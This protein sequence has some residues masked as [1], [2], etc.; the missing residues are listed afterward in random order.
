MDNPVLRRGPD[1]R[2]PP[3]GGSERIR[4]GMLVVPAEMGWI[5][6]R[7]ATDLISR[8]LRKEIRRGMFIMP[9]PRGML[10]MPAEAYAAMKNGLKF[11]TVNRYPCPD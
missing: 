7:D 1:K 6:K 4:R 9:V 10:V 2:V 11:A 5:I 8:S 3:T